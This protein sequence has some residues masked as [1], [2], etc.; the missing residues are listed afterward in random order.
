MAKFFCSW[1]TDTSRLP[2]DPKEMMAMEMKMLEMTKQS[3]KEGGASD[4]G[5]FI[6]GH[7]GYAI[8]EGDAA[9]V[10]K[11]LWQFVPYVKFDV[12]IQFIFSPYGP[13]VF[14]GVESCPF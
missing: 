7:K 4:W 5:C 12:N 9:D 14:I 2:T 6:E 10:A 8:G 3:L 11:A 1:E 13:G